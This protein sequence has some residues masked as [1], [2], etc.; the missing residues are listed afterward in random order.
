MSLTA[1]ISGLNAAVFHTV[2][3]PV[4]SAWTKASWASGNLSASISG[5]FWLNSN[6][7]PFEVRM[8]G[9][10]N[11]G[12]V[13]GDATNKCQVAATQVFLA[14]VSTTVT[15]TSVSGMT[16]ATTSGN[17]FLYVIV[18]SSS[19]LSVVS[20]AASAAA[21]ASTTP[22]ISSTAITIGVVRRLESG[23]TTVAASEISIANPDRE[24]AN[25]ANLKYLRPLKGRVDFAT[26]P[27]TPHSASGSTSQPA[28]VYIR[29]YSHNDNEQKIALI[30]NWDIGVT[31]NREEFDHQN[32]IA[33]QTEGGRLSYSFSAE[34]WVNAADPQMFKHI[35]DPATKSD[36]IVKMFIKQAT[37][38]LY[39][40]AQIGFDQTITSPDNAK[41]SKSITGNVVGLVEH[42]TS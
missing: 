32:A 19:G 30:R 2:S 1:P 33:S 42:F 11:G 41:H 37:T 17:E 31:E 29:A 15:A 16:K 6:A 23:S 22:L 9:V 35:N 20:A 26:A 39:W 25:K 38:T 13:T 40:V 7:H 12:A 18:Y 10:L 27:I 5:N 24:Y 34:K 4:Q 3:T 21:G 36:F 8:N 14:G 28:A